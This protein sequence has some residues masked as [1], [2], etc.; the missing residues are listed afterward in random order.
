MYGFVYHALQKLI[1]HDHGQDIWEEICVKANL[2]DQDS[3]S[4][5]EGRMYNDQ[6]LSDLVNV[7]CEVLGMRSNEIYEQFGEKFFEHCMS[8]RFEKILQCLGGN[9]R[10]FICGL[11][12]LHEQLLFQFPGMQAP[13][14]RV[15]SKHGSEVLIVYYNSVRNDLQYMV[16]GMLK[17][18]AKRM[19]QSHVDVVVDSCN[20]YDDC[21]KFIVRPTDFSGAVKIL[22][23]RRQ[24]RMVR[25]DCQV[26]AYKSTISSKTFCKAI[27]FHIVFDREMVVFQAGISMRRVLPSLVVGRTKVSEILEIVRPHVNIDFNSILSRPNSM[28]LLRTN[29][30]VLDSSTLSTISQDDIERIESPSM[31]FK[32]QMLYLE[33]TDNICFLCSPM[34][35]NLDGLNEKGLYLSDI[36]IHDATRDL[37]LVSEHRNAECALTQRLQILTDKLQQTGRELKKEQQ[38]TDKL[39]YSILPPSV[40]NEL[41]LKRPVKAKRFE[42]VTVLFSGIV[43]FAGY[44][45]DITEPMDIV[46]LL[47][48]IYLTFDGLMDMFDEVYKVETVGDKYMAVSGLPTKCNTHANQIAKMALD[49]MDAADSISI[50]GQPFRITIGIHSGD[51]V[52][53]VVGQKL[54][55]YCLFGNTVNIASRTETTGCKGKI[56]VSE[57]AYRCLQNPR[58]PSLKFETRGPI[59]MKGKKEPMLTY[60]LTRSG[61]Y[62][63]ADGRA[64][65]T[66]VRV[67]I[68]PSSTS[69]SMK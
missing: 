53:G 14:F 26:A 16:V 38:L 51:V 25:E 68:R 65:E 28:F 22:P 35:L 56:N 59:A 3:C 24:S 63:S 31:R 29:E 18:V 5:D 42:V 9:L 36:P 52:A 4:F 64:G 21:T 61:R 2:G 19:Y 32:G 34:V 62:A 23:K 40:A 17:A 39:L 37:I 33:E 43:N 48:N 49:M 55:R 50:G 20:E 67:V 12:N 66:N 54:P 6:D 7:A 11:D 58:D 45:N 1:E 13:S 15:D 57:P 46:S 30:G 60:F 10:D 44:C 47:N 69:S 41:R 27:P 8:S